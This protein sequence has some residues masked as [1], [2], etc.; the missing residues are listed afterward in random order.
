MG[1]SFVF[2]IWKLLGGL[3]ILSVEFSISHVPS[4]RLLSA[5]PTSTLSTYNV[6]SSQI[7]AL[8][9]LY[10]H[11]NGSQW[12]WKTPESIYG[13][14]WNF[15][16]SNPNPCAAR[17]QGISCSSNCSV[18]PCMITGIE[19]DD[20]DLNG[21]LVPSIGNISSLQRLTISNNFNLS[22]KLSVF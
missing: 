15:S 22:G 16:L 18:T 19:L 20:Y 14:I 12:M 21:R 13:A 6:P 10:N 7:L 5:P 1:Q 17:W 3:L 2:Y 4:L 9:D 8:Q 11:T